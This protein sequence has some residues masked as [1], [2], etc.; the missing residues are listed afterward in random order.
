MNTLRLNYLLLLMALVLLAANMAVAVEPSAEVSPLA[1]TGPKPAP[2]EPPGPE[3]IDG[4]IRRGVEFLLERQ[5]GDGSWGSHRTGRPSNV[6]APVPGA[7]HAF[8]AA[9]TSL[10]VATLIESGGDDPAV[11]AALDRAERWMALNLPSL[12]RATPDAIYNNWGHIYA[13]QALALMHRRHEG[14]PER[15]EAIR[16]HLDQQIDRLGRYEFLSGGWAYYDFDA[17]TQ[18]P[19][20]PSTS[21]MTAAALIALDEAKRVGVN[22]PRRLT[23]RAIES[24]ERQRKPDF[25]YA[26]AESFVFHPMHVINRPAGSLG[27]SQACNAALRIWGDQR[28]TDEVLTTWLDRLFARNGWLCIGRKRPIPHESWFAVAGYFFYFGHYYAARCI[29][30]LPPEQQEPYKHQMAH[31]IL[32]LQEADGSWWDFPLYD[33]HQQYGTAFA[34]MTLA[35]CR[36]D[37]TAGTPSAA[38]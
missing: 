28:V 9:T 36:A 37:A 16:A 18:R 15:Q 32:A 25:S 3:T 35:R 29:E 26:Y 7:H 22:V 8:R 17:G 2:V 38:R 11:M 24:I 12:R 21:F 19:S 1:T 13:V 5:N 34:L 27:R 6:F 10:C 20:G 14:R 31:V 4:A 23:D 30:L 33:Y